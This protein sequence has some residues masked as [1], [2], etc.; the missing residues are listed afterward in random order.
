MILLSIL[1][2]SLPL[3]DYPVNEIL[4][5]FVCSN[6]SLHMLK[7]RLLWSFSSYIINFISELLSKLLFS[8]YK[9]G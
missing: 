8:C 9:C 1:T 7:P 2:I 4:N 3:R 6:D 5:F